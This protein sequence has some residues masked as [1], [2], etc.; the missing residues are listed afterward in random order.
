MKI[1]C[2]DDNS[3]IDGI[4]G[5]SLFGKIKNITINYKNKVIESNS[6]EISGIK[7]PL[8]YMNTLGL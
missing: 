1:I 6:P 2:S 5:L 3:T 4:E 7:T 8:Y